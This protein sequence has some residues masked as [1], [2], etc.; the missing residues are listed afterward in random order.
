MALASEGRMR[1]LPCQRLGRPRPLLGWYM[2]GTIFVSSCRRV[3]TPGPY[4]LCR[5]TRKS[6]IRYSRIADHGRPEGKPVGS[7][8]LKFPARPAPNES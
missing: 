1:E 7:A 8:R 3:C 2:C 6:R 4:L 5:L